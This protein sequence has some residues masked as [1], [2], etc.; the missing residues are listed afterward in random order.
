MNIL[1]MTN[2]FTPFLGGVARSVSAFTRELRRMGH[3]VVVVAPEFEN[4]PPLEEGV[5]RVPAIQHFNGSDF[6]VS[7]P[8]P[9]YLSTH[10]EKFK[11]DIVHS[12][13]P[14]LLGSTAMRIASWFECP[15]VFTYH[16]MYEDY[17]HYVPAHARQLRGFVM[18]L[19]KG[20]C[21]LCDHV[22]APSQS[23]AEMVRLRGVK[24]PVTV[25][26]T[27]VYTRQFERG[28]GA[29]FRQSHGIPA[30]ALV[31]GYVG[32]L[33]PEKNLAFLA[34]V[35]RSVAVGPHRGHFLVVGSGPS[36][37]KMW[38]IFRA[39]D[40]GDHLHLIGPL[41]GRELANAYHAMDVFAFASHTE[42]Q[43]MVLTEAMAAGRPV[44]AV[45][46]PG[47]REVV[48]ERENGRLLPS[49]NV[50]AFVGALQEMAETPLPQ[51]LAYERAARATAAEFAMET[52]AR[53]L[54]EVYEALL[55]RETSG[56]K[57]DSVW[58]RAKE[59]IRAEWELMKNVAEAAAI[60][61]K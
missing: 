21:N 38:E 40:L 31:I 37:A 5:I 18:S 15:L 9:G 2:T 12:H 60:A 47:V 61:L 28:D 11:P 24:T 14:H 50:P 4:A 43:G 58:G 3:D 56:W 27:G 55:N 13:H 29:G 41:E 1:M 19:V 23:I 33:A 44:V 46:A 6:S 45:D 51:R 39:W 48:R 10:L 16:T 57:D 32:R 25:V 17:L 20:Y 34:E 30:G 42:T 7:L 59:E 36:A 52:S 49:D 53:K 54:A 8:I 22:I 26:P 35:A